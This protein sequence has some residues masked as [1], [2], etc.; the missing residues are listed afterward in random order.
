MFVLGFS[1]RHKLLPFRAIGRPR[2]YIFFFFF[3]FKIILLRI[4]T[5]MVLLIYCLGFR[6]LPLQ[7][8]FEFGSFLKKNNEFNF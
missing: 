2:I 8:S 4:F 3:F 1:P 7:I 6:M 5:V